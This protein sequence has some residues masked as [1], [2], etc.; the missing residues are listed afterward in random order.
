MAAV[1]AMAGSATLPV[2]PRRTVNQGSTQ[3]CVSCALGAAMEARN[4]SWDPLSPVFHYHV[5]RF[6]KGAVADAE[7][8]LT[9]DAGFA[10]L[11]TH[12]ICREAL[13]TS[14]F[15]APG[16]ASTPTAA[17]FAD[18]AARRMRRVGVSFPKKEI[19]GTSRVTS[20]REHLRSGNPV[21]MAFSLPMGYP[22]TFLNADHEWLDPQAPG[23]SA[24]R[25]CALVVAFDDLRGG[26]VVR[27]AVRVFDS[28]GRGAFDSGGWWMGYRVLDSAIV[29]E[30]WA[31]I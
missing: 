27:G 10:T 3:C 16:T 24:S 5:T 12:G 2:L 31:L 29:Q 23:P 1:G 20:V 26:G 14:V 25:H 7:G 19:G 8:R 18:A 13:H 30:A 15:D 22:S 11:I 17:A 4:A 9:L 28:F 21:V 6:V